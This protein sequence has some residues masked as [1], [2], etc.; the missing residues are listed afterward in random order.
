MAYTLTQASNPMSIGEQQYGSGGSIQFTKFTSCIGVIAKVK[1]KKEVI[2]IH[3]VMIDEDGN[4]FS[5]GDVSTVTGVLNGASYDPNQV[6]LI[7]AISYWTESNKAAYDA[8]VKAIKPTNTYPLADGVYGAT[9][10]ED[11]LIELT[12]V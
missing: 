6:V 7:G 4:K 11:G 12:Y 9:I 10:D 8:L 3:L 1:N 5:T 2:G